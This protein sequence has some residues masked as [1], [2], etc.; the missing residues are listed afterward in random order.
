MRSLASDRW[1]GVCDAST[2]DLLFSIRQ[3][4]NGDGLVSRWIKLEKEGNENEKFEWKNQIEYQIYW[5]G[6][7]HVLKTDEKSS[8][9]LKI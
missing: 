8:T 7:S 1:S 3:W 9:K 6:F 4:I 5:I 2:V